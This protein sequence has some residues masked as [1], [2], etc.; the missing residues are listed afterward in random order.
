MRL[1][2][3]RWDPTKS[4]GT[5]CR[6][7]AAGRWLG[8]PR[9]RST[10]TL[11]RGGERRQRVEACLR[12][13]RGPVCLLRA[14]TDGRALAAAQGEFLPQSRRSE[15]YKAG[16]QAD[17]RDSLGRLVEGH[18]CEVSRHGDGEEADADGEELNRFALRSQEVPERPREDCERDEI[19]GKDEVVRPFDA[20][21]I[22]QKLEIVPERLVKAEE[23]V[24]GEQGQAP[25]A[26]RS[27]NVI[28]D[29]L[30]AATSPTE[31]S[32]SGAGRDSSSA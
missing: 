8:R 5:G 22:G 12:Q 14:G 24:G 17:R 13:H 10:T 11:A 3:S 18:T 2:R 1:G 4:P 26:V 25:A 15:D 32:L 21:K 23:L 28:S 29:M 31:L 9:S 20:R 27:N 6:S 19:A 16:Q 30:A 7:P